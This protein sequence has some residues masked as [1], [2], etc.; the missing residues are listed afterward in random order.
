MTPA[1]LTHGPEPDPT[2]LAQL[3]RVLGHVENVLNKIAALM[4]FLIMLGTVIQIFARLA[5]Q[6][7]KG[8]FELSEQSIAVFAFLGAAYAQR[9]S[10]HIRMELVVGAV[11][12]RARWMIEALATFVAIAV[13]TVLVLYSY[14]F[15][16][17]AV[18]LGDTTLDY[19]YPTWPS[20]LLVPIALFVW[21]MRLVLEFFGFMRLVIDPSRTPVAVPVIKSAA[22]TAQSEAA[23]TFGHDEAGPDRNERA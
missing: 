7:V 3:D 13:V 19:G 6:P 1:S 10:G 8:F 23:E 5:G 4:I 9:L 15:F 18:T 21:W 11:S 2:L 20:K 17:D 22:D 14:W 16:L 12:G